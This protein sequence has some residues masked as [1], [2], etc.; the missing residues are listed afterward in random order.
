V[1]SEIYFVSTLTTVYREYIPTGFKVIV[2]SEVG[3][4]TDK[5]ADFLPAK[6]SLNS[7]T[8]IVTTLSNHHYNF[9]IIWKYFIII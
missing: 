9:K 6:W 1:N 2:K 4:F 8:D 3:G 5:S 7:G